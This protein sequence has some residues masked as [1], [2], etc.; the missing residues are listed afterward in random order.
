[1]AYG[2]RNIAAPDAVWA[3][4][5]QRM[6]NRLPLWARA[7]I[8][9]V[10]SVFQNLVNPMAY[11]F[12]E[13]YADII[14]NSRN[15]F[16]TTASL[17]DQNFLYTLQLDM[18]FAFQYVEHQ[19]GKLTF[20]P[21]TV[22]ATLADSTTV[23]PEI[24]DPNL[25]E[26]IDRDN[27]LPTRIDATLVTSGATNTIL[28]ST[29]I[30]NISLATINDD[31]LEY[32]GVVFIEI[33]GADSFGW[34][35]QRGKLVVPKVVIKGRPVERNYDETIEEDIVFLTNTIVQSKYNWDV[36][37]SIEVRGIDGDTATIALTAGFER[38]FV[39]N[40]YAS[41][42]TTLNEY[43]LLYALRGDYSPSAGEYTPFIQHKTYDTAV[44][45]LLR[46][47][48]ASL[49]IEH[50]VGLVPT[51]DTYFTEPFL[52]L[53]RIPN[54]RWLVCV[55]DTSLYFT[56]S[57]LPHPLSQLSEDLSGETLL[58][59]ALKDRTPGPELRIM[60][61]V[62]DQVFTDAEGDLILTTNHQKKTRGVVATRLSCTIESPVTDPTTTYYAWDGT[63]INILTDPL[64][65]WVPSPGD[66]STV[67]GWQ[68]QSIVVDMTSLANHMFY[69]ATWKLETE[70]IGKEFETDTTIVYAPYHIVD[71]T[72]PLPSSLSGNIQAI[73]INSNQDLVALT[74]TGQIWKFSLYYD[75]YLIDYQKNKLWFLEDYESVVVSSD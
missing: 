12:D 54:S 36:I 55:S 71:K 61:D 39:E 13:Q 27:I 24:L 25:P 4:S 46:Q 70:F 18:D 1:M 51:H 17:T 35:D 41:L 67:D 53:E 50:E 44:S 32:T 45:S 75:Y 66:S 16:L 74:T 21:P 65:A 3:W 58:S 72:I 47:G 7:R 40:P 60:I 52:D 20:T 31:A 38:G 68:E 48:E 19:A 43:P 6:A 2:G 64:Q 63:V 15:Y 59:K 57:K 9:G 26:M 30:E 49:I 33:S 34:R 8:E 14:Q 37:D 22:T 62:H 42:S 73:S 11:Y 5:T 23:T 29:L 28:A 10:D 69:T 56:D